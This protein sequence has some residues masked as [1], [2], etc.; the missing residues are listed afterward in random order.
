MWSLLDHHLIGATK[1]VEKIYYNK[2]VL[3]KQKS[4]A[5]LT[6]RGLINYYKGQN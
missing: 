1:L 2:R 4:K 3:L 5:H 6:K